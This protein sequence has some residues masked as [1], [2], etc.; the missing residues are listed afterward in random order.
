MATKFKPGDPVL[1]RAD[2]KPGHVRTPG[3]V[4]GRMGRIEEV[5]G[6]FENPEILAYG[7]PSGPK[8]PLYKVSF[9]QTDLWEGYAGSTGDALYVD[10]YEHWLEP[11]GEEA[12]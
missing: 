2:K 9:R 3:Y 1:V 5:L 11:A 8:K 6:V 4:R 12:R 10:I 7:G